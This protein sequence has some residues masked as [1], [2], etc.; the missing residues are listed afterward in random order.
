MLP[1]AGTW[2][3]ENRVDIAGNEMD[4]QRENGS[5]LQRRKEKDVIGKN[6]Q[7]RGVAGLCKLD[8]HVEGRSEALR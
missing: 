1:L 5:G 8:L 6:S 7:L 4:V 3:Q 2:S